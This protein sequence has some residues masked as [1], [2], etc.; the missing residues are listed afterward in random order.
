MAL[1]CCFEDQIVCLIYPLMFSFVIIYKFLI[2]NE[3]VSQFHVFSGVLVP[4]KSS[5]C[6]C[7]NHAGKVTNKASKYIIPLKQCGLS[8]KYAIIINNGLS[9]AARNITYN[10]H[11]N[12]VK[13]GKLSSSLW[14]INILYSSCMISH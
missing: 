12:C 8:P 4:D 2:V 7:H 9:K 5:K 11:Y 3:S 6:W 10:A 13:S 14:L 1:I